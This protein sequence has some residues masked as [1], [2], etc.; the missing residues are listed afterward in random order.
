MIE[1]Y[2]YLSKQY[3]I[4]IIIIIIIIVAKSL[5]LKSA[6]GIPGVWCSYILYSLCFNKLVSPPHSA[7]FAVLSD[8]YSVRKM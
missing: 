5:F 2:F 1:L 6:A 3:S 7:M 8:T 4:I